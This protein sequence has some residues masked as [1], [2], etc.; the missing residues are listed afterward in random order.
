MIAEIKRGIKLIRYG[1]GVKRNLIGGMLLCILGIGMCC[2]ANDSFIIIGALYMMLGP[3]MIIQVMYSLLYSNMVGA[4]PRRRGIEI[5]I[6]DWIHI[7]TGAIGYIVFM[8]VA[9]VRVN[10][11]PDKAQNIMQGIILASVGI[12]AVFVCFGACYKYYWQSMIL[13]FIVFFSVYGVGMIIM[14]A[15]QLHFTLTMAWTAGVSLAFIAAGVF[16]SCVL[17][18]LVYKKVLSPT[19]CGTG[20]RKAMQ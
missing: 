20:L 12:A 17:R 18:R 3:I 2:V 8:I 14:R 13:F 11:A 10:G 16:L 7:L 4:S 19:A 5:L 1:Y 9:V 6:A 15:I